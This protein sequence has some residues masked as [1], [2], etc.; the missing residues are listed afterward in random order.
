MSEEHNEEELD[1]PVDPNVPSCH[2][3]VAGTQV[4]SLSITLRNTCSC[5]V[6][7]KLM[8]KMISVIPMLLVVNDENRPRIHEKGSDIARAAKPLWPTYQIK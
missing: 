6:V 8:C 1:S 2:C 3:R 7:C 5:H 4:K